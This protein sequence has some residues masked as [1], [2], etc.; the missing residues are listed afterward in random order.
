MRPPRPRPYFR[1]N[2]FRTGDVGS[3]DTEG[4]LFIVGRI[5]EMIHKGQKVVPAK[6]QA[7]GPRVACD[8]ERSKLTLSVPS[9][10]P[11]FHVGWEGQREPCPI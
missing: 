6:A 2:W 4:Y 9:D 11:D 1:N 7:L 5:K 3:L 8:N 10:A